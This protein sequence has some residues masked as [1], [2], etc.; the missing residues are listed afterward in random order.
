MAAPRP[1]GDPVE[2]AV[3]AALLCEPSCRERF[4]ARGTLEWMS[5]GPLRDAADFVSGRSE[6]PGLLPVDEAPR[7]VRGV[8]TPLLVQDADPRPAYAVLEAKLE[9]RFL[10]ARA[11][12]LLRELRQAE[13]EGTTARLEGLL[14]EKQELDRALASTRRLASGRT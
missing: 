8:L 5:A 2:R 11:S 1:E 12:R 14:R 4:R 6:P 3:V 9:L 7:E 13:G 10:E